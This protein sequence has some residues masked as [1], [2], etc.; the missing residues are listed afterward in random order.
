MLKGVNLVERVQAIKAQR[1]DWFGNTN[2]SE[3][4]AFVGYALSFPDSFLALIDTYDTCK[5]GLLNF[6]AVALALHELG[7]TAKGVRL[8]SGDLAYLSKECRRK[9]TEAAEQFKDQ[10]S[11]SVRQSVRQ[12]VSRS[13][14]QSL[15]R[16]V[17]RSRRVFLE[18][19]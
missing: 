7:Y 18:I 10:V 11:Q 4:A 15:A 17:A 19:C 6:V 3:L 2:E 13:V 9:L 14:G 12:S 5:S 1:E 16:S 8:D